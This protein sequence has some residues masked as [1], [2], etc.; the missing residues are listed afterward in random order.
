MAGPAA[1]GRPK[2]AWMLRRLSWW[3]MAALA[4]V[5]AVTAACGGG[6]AANGRTVMVFAAASLADPFSELAADFEAAHPE[7]NVTFNFA[8]S[9]ALVTQLGQGARGEVLATADERTMRRALDEGLIEGEGQVFARNR[10]AIVVPAS[11]PGGVSTAADLARPGLK[12]VL[13]QEETPV[14]AYAREALALLAGDPA[15]GD[16]FAERVLANVVSEEPSVKS[17]VVK[18]QL[19]E[20]DAGIVYVTDVTPEIADDV[21]LVGIPD[22]YNVTAT[23]PIALTR[24][25]AADPEAW[26]FIDFVLSDAGQRTLETYGFIAIR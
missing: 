15:N 12:I 22:A 21:T 17:V 2:E 1:Q 24:E 23:Y 7:V 14:G 11:N 8:G 19:G 5:A 4:L 20:A 26:G 3:S 13:A 18:V 16:G 9:P 6:D 25:G 10:L